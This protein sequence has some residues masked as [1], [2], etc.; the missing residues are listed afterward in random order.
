MTRT[1]I[2]AALALVTF[3]TV[4]DARPRAAQGLAAECG[5]TMPCGETDAQ[6]DRARYAEPRTGRAPSQGGRPAGCPSRWCGCWLG[7][8]LGIA[9]R[10]LWLARNW[11]GVGRP[12][13]GPRSGAIAVWRSHVGIVKAVEG[14]RIQVLSGNDGNAVR[15][16]WRSSAGVI[17]WRVL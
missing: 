3:S 16:R 10:D 11:A 8:H 5:V 13:G 17:A 6:A 4:A 1:I 15:E 14:K 12:A 2:L 7:K 9:R